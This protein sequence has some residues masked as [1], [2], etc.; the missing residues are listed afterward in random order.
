MESLG[1]LRSTHHPVQTWKSQNTNRVGV[2]YLSPHANKLCLL[3]HLLFILHS[4]PPLLMGKE[5]IGK[6]G[7]VSE[8][9]LIIEKH[10]F[11]HGYSGIYADTK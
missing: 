10:R 7:C 8:W 2:S 5:G 3:P 1:T 6:G 4:A 9:K 11:A